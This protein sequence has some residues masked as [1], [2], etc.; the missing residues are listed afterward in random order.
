MPRN[1]ADEGRSVSLGYVKA[2]AQTYVAIAVSRTLI[3]RNR[4]CFCSLKLRKSVAR[5][6]FASGLTKVLRIGIQYFVP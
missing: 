6:S 1:V 2:A 4:A 3:G 5:I